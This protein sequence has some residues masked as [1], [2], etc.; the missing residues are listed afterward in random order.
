M[1]AGFH[2]AAWQLVRGDHQTAE[3]T[4]AS[5]VSRVRGE[6][7]LLLLQPILGLIHAKKG[8]F[9]GAIAIAESFDVHDE[10]EGAL[11]VA[12][13]ND[14]AVLQGSAGDAL[15]AKQTLESAL[16]TAR[17]RTHKLTRAVLVS[18]VA[19]A[20]GRTG[21]L[22]ASRRSF[23]EA[24]LTFKSGRK[25]DPGDLGL[26]SNLR[27]I[28]IRQ[29]QAGF[30]SMAMRSTF[31]IEHVLPGSA[32]RLHVDALASVARSLAGKPPIPWWYPRRFNFFWVWD[33]IDPVGG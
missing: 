19:A 23:A 3:Q 24:A 18:T 20:Q 14:I 11:R 28:A 33:R 31:D 22:E 25:M 10:N 16:K 21:D 6:S 9:D 4:I 7:G 8:N 32:E 27:D 15:A 1:A 26:A 30:A 17:G 29:A 5:T 13:L 2:I 12:L